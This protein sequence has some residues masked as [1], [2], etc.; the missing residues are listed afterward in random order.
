MVHEIGMYEMIVKSGYSTNGYSRECQWY[1]DTR[2]KVILI[3]GDVWNVKWLAYIHP[4]VLHMS[5]CYGH[6][7]IPV[8]MHLK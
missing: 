8:V 5:R 3:N 2:I 4:V 7:Q 6:A 1:A